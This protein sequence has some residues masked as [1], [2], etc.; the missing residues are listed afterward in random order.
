[1][2]IGLTL[3]YFSPLIYLLCI[4]FIASRQ[5]AL[6]LLVHDAAHFRIS[7]NKH[8]ND[9]FSNTLASFPCLIGTHAYRLHHLQHH[10]YLNTDNDPDWARKIH[11]KEWQFPMPAK[12]LF[13]LLTKQI[14]VGGYDWIRLVT[15]MFLSH[16]RLKNNDPRKKEALLLLGFVGICITIALAFN[17]TTQLFLFWFVPLLTVFPMLQRFRSITEHFAADKDFILNQTRNTDSHWL[18]RIFLSPHSTNRHL[19]HHLFPSVPHY[20]LEKLHKN[21]LSTDLIYANNQH[22]NSTYLWPSKN[23]VWKDLTTRTKS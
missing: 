20:N 3:T 16:W 18:E 22:L 1:M 6:A 2:A 11:L 17:F 23:S 13:L 8:L 4:L 9:F 7:K 19:L 5:H 15:S 12:S 10:Q 21:L 14:F